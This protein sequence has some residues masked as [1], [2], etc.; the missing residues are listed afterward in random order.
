MH[1]R[2]LEYARALLFAKKLLRYAW[3][4]S[5]SSIELYAYELIARIYF[6]LNDFELSQY[7][8]DRGSDGKI[9]AYSSAIRA[10]AISSTLVA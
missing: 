6:Y 5:H 3:L 9:E 8:H 7:F 2:R 1:L 10:M 4:Y